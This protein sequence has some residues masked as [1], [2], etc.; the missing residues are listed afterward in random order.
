MPRRCLPILIALALA[1][2]VSQSPTPTQ[3][4][5]SPAELEAMVAEPLEAARAG[6]LPGAQRAFEALLARSDVEQAPDLLSA[7]G[8]GLYSQG[9]GDWDSDGER[10]RRASVPY[11][12]RAIPATE[13]RFGPDH[14]EVALA[15]NTY[16][17]VLRA[18]SPEDPPRQADSAYAR[19]YA[20]REKTL[21][22]GNAETLFVLFRLA[23]LKGLPSRT[24]GDPARIAEAADM[25]RAVIR[26]R[27]A[28]PDPDPRAGTPENVRLALI[29]MY[30]GNGR[31]AEAVAVARTTELV[32]ENRN[33]RCDVGPGRAAIA[34]VLRERGRTEEAKAALNP[35]ADPPAGC[36]FDPPF[37]RT[38]N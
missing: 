9:A 32:D 7:F 27:E 5:L 18:L 24:G 33:W 29:E 22:R 28:N 23:E 3:D 15:L 12:E 14:P 17:D 13:K 34:A 21:G 1:A 25:F 4:R 35:P 11:L 6:D 8:V 37:L 36:L 38:R 19:A 31:T 10:F 20:I 16:G 2:C 26:G 30:V